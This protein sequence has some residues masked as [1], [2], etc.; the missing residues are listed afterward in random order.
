[1]IG[2]MRKV[3]DKYLEHSGK[4]AADFEPVS[5]PSIDDHQITREDFEVRGELANDAAKIVMKAL[6]CARFVRYDCL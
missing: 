3:V 4:N 6:Y 5:T 1:M 2:L